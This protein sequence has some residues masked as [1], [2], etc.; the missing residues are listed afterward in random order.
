VL[1]AIFGQLAEHNE[2]VRWGDRRRN[3]TATSIY[4][5]DCFP[6]RS[7]FTWCATAAM[8]RFRFATPASGRP[9][10]V[11][12]RLIG[13]AEAVAQTTLAQFGYELAFRGR[14]RAVSQ[15][16]QFYWWMRGRTAR[17]I[18]PASWPDNWYQLSLR[19]RTALPRVFRR[20]RVPPQDV[21]AI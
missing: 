12:L 3:T 7:S 9:T 21:K 11:Q 8:S 13:A 17:P 10:H 4:F 14:A 15:R 19:A 2:M 5:T 16:Q 1:D 18:M 6:T 20:D